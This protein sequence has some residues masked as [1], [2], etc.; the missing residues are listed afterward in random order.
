MPPTHAEEK[1]TLL[2]RP[3]R[4][5]ILSGTQVLTEHVRAVKTGECIAKPEHLQELW[6]LS[7]G[8]DTPPDPQWSLTFETQVQARPLTCYEE[9]AP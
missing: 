8:S 1:L 9:A 4:V 6:K 5:L 3:D 7:V 2:R